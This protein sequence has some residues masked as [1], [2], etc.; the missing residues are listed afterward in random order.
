MRDCYIIEYSAFN[1]IDHNRI[2]SYFAGPDFPI[3]EMFTPYVEAAYDGPREEMEGYL[4]DIIDRYNTFT[5]S[6]LLPPIDEQLLQLRQIDDCH[7]E[8]IRD[9]LCSFGVETD[10][11]I[12]F[13]TGWLAHCPD[14][15]WFCG[16]I[17]SSSSSFVRQRVEDGPVDQKIIERMAEQS[18]WN[19]GEPD[20][21]LTF[22]RSFN[23]QIDEDGI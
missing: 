23:R 16:L 14:G 15:S 12:A 17:F 19:G 7:A 8:I 18:L 13:R 2:T 6:A 4:Y 10:G 9:Y 22:V 5:E 11:V 1:I 21:V 3:T 20:R